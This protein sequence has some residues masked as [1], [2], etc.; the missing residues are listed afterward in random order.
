MLP[1]VGASSRGDA[2]VERPGEGKADFEQAVAQAAGVEAQPQP[3]PSEQPEQDIP[4]AVLAPGAQESLDPRTS[5]IVAGVVRLPHALEHL[6]R[7]DPTAAAMLELVTRRPAAP[8]PATATNAEEVAALGPAVPDR[9]GSEGHATRSR[10]DGPSWPDPPAPPRS[11]ANTAAGAPGPSAAGTTT[12]SAPATTPNPTMRPDSTVVPAAGSS[13]PPV[14]V[15]PQAAPALLPRVAPEGLTVRVP[16][17]PVGVRVIGAAPR[18]AA[19]ARAHPSIEAQIARGLSAALRQREGTVTLKLTPES[20]G[21]VRVRVSV[22]EGIVNVRIEAEADSARRLLGDNVAA[23]RLA[24][25]DQGLRIERIEVA[26]PRDAATNG[27]TE[28]Q[29]GSHGEASGDPSRRDDEPGR[30]GGAWVA[31]A[32]PTDRR[33]P[34]PDSPGGAQ[35]RGGA[36]GLTPQSTG[37]ARER[38][39]PALDVTA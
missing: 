28:G 36:D 9:P 13:T 24:L 12:A 2:T 30:R 6:A 31:T 17:S 5:L 10:W 16:P 21:V 33:R 4:S 14:T 26:G 32:I 18:S 34:G 35:A 38:S 8:M 15:M 23:L 19:V 11:A 29:T 1:R 27:A 37:H 22:S 7:F 25:E 39:G 3:A 20:L